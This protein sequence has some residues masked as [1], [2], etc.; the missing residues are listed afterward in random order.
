V[1]IDARQSLDLTGGMSH[2]VNGPDSPATDIIE[3]TDDWACS[4]SQLNLTR[5]EQFWPDTYYVG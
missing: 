3:Y 1:G 4:E 5:Y 2:G